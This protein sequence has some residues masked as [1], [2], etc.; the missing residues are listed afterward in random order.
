MIQKTVGDPTDAPAQHPHRNLAK[1]RSSF[2]EPIQQ[3]LTLIRR[4]DGVAHGHAGEQLHGLV[5]RRTVVS[6][7]EHKRVE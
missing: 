4:Q 6:G 7:G 5:H 2:F 1:R 3:A